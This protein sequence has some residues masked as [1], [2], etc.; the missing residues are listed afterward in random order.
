MLGSKK[1]CS[2]GME[3][4]PGLVELEVAVPTCV[5]PCGRY[6]GEPPRTPRGKGTSVRKDYQNEEI[7]TSRPAVPEQVS[8]ALAELAGW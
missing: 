1:G 4:V 6:S 7:D 3:L 8:V 2:A 5:L